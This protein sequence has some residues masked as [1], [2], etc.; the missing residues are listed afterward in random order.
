MEKLIKKIVR[1]A[2]LLDRINYEKDA[3][4]LTKIAEHLVEEKKA[5]K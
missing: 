1:V 3:E 4:M 2:N 5:P